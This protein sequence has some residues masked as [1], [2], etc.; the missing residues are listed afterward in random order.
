VNG[1]LGV[2]LA[3]GRSTRMGRDKA[4]LPFRGSTLVEGALALLRAV[5]AEVVIAGSR[6]DLACFAPVLADLHPGCGPLSGIE[7][8]LVYAADAGYERILCLPVDLP[9]LPEAFPRLLLER[10]ALTGA[11]AT[12]STL[13]GRAQPLCCVFRP[14]LLPR[15]TAALDSGNYKVMRPLETLSAGQLDLF[16]LESVT[17]SQPVW[18][19]GHAPLYRWFENINTPD[20]LNRL[21]SSATLEAP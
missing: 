9:L 11:P 5:A 15:I 2:V 8:A 1:V 17:A 14:A 21:S 10:S 6:P 13:G 7:A 18:L 20:A 4:L 12:V 16:A 19:D 3:G